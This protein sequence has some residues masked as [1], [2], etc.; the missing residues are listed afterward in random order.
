MKRCEEEGLRAPPSAAQV[1]DWELS[2]SAWPALRAIKGRLQFWKRGMPTEL[3]VNLDAGGVACPCSRCRACRCLSLRGELVVRLGSARVTRVQDDHIPRST[4]DDVAHNDVR[5][6]VFA[7][8][9]R[10]SSSL[11]ASSAWWAD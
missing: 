9:R 8:R 6:L 1:S 7:R 11:R 2:V 10:G 3:P 4:Q 5:P